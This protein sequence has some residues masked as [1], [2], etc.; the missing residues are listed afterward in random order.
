MARVAYVIERDLSTLPEALDELLGRD[1][2]AAARHEYRSYCL[3]EG[4]GAEAPN[5][6][7]QEVER[8]LNS[9]SPQRS[10]PSPGASKPKQK[11]A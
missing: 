3:G 11:T 9:A 10:S 1:S 5:G 7:F 2:L 8:I 6:F 4:L